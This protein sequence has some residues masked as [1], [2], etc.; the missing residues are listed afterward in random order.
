MMYY[1]HEYNEKEFENYEECRENLLE[2]LEERD[3]AEKLD[4]SLEEIIFRFGRRA[5][6]QIF[7]DWLDDKIIE[8]EEMAIEDLITEYEDEEV[9]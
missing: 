6:N 8:A 1:V 2:Y 9:S 3:I 7:I 4:L 5:N